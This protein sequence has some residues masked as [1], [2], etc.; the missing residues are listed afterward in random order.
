MPHQFPDEL[1]HLTPDARRLR[2]IE[3]ARIRRIPPGT[4]RFR[5]DLLKDVAR[6]RTRGSGRF[7]SRSPAWLNVAIAPSGWFSSCAM[8]LAISASA[9]M[10]ESS[11]SRRGCFPTKP[12]AFEFVKFHLF[13]GYRPPQAASLEDSGQVCRFPGLIR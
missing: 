3:Q 2:M 7:N 10:R 5:M 13:R 1:E 4:H 9:A 11:S 8:P 6:A 12:N